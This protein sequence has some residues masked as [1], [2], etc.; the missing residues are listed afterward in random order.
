M[1]I[2]ER[3]VEIL[4]NLGKYHPDLAL[5][6]Q[7]PSKRLIPLGDYVKRGMSSGAVKTVYNFTLAGGT[8]GTTLDLSKIVPKNAIVTRVYTRVIDA[9][10]SAGTPVWSLKAGVVLVAIADATALTGIEEISAL[11]H[12]PSEAKLS[13][14]LSG[15]DVTAGKVEFYVEYVLG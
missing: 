11:V 6:E 12:V 5:L 1:T 3:E 4:N 13:L 14:D 15:D 2:S 7:P 8:A 10:T 9:V